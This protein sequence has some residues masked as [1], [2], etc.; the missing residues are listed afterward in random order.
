MTD[1]NSSSSFKQERS[2]NITSRSVG[3][4]T[5]AYRSRRTK[6]VAN[7]CAR[8]R[9]KG[10]TRTRGARRAAAQGDLAARLPRDLD[11][12]TTAT[13]RPAVPAATTPIALVAN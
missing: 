4:L 13:P 12:E 2:G 10:R 6:T 7:I 8:E 1:K 5:S 11:L 9:R 3:G